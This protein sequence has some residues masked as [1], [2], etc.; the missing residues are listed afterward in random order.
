MLIREQS[1]EDWARTRGLIPSDQ[2][3]SFDR[4][5]KGLAT[6]NWENAEHERVLPK[7]S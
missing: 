7:A 3:L 2:P 1:V 5:L 6:G 4:Y